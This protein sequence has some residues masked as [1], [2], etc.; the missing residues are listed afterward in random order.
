MVLLILGISKLCV[1]A[2]KPPKR[3]ILLLHLHCGLDQLSLPWGVEAG[4]MRCEHGAGSQSTFE[5][6]GSSASAASQS[7]LSDDEGEQAVHDSVTSLRYAPSPV[8]AA[9]DVSKGAKLVPVAHG[10]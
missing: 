5:R 10:H 6:A 4:L 3:V 7:P 8:S 2:E 9:P 1:E